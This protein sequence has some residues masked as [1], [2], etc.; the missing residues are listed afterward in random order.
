MWSLTRS[1]LGLRNGDKDSSAR[2]TTDTADHGMG[3]KDLVTPFAGGWETTGKATDS[4]HCAL[5]QGGKSQR[6]PPACV[7]RVTSGSA[8]SKEQKRVLK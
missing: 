3:G 7:E 4:K 5:S 1:G 2:K 8:S 6:E